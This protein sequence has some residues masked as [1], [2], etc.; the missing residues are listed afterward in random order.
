MLFAAALMVVGGTGAFFSD[1]ETSTGNVFTAG[2]IDLLVNHSAQSYNGV[3]CQTCGVEIVSSE[4]TRVVDSSAGAASEGDLPKNAELIANPNPNW[5]DANDPA[6][7][8]AEWIWVEPEVDVAD[9]T[10]D[11]EYT[12]EDVFSLQGPIALT[13]FELEIAS[14]NGYKI[15]LNGTTIVDR[16]SVEDT[17]TGLNPL[18]SQ[19]QTD[20]QNA[21]IENGQNT[22][23]I[24]V[25]NHEGVENPDQ[26]PAG[27]IYKIE[28]TNEDC[29]AGV[30]DFQA[31]CEL[32]QSIDLT[33]ESFFDFSDIKPQDEGTNRISLTVED[34]EA[35][36]CLGVANPENIENS[37]LDIEQEAG[38]DS[39][40][41]GE[42][43][44][45]LQVAGWYTDAAGNLGNMLFG[46]TAADDLESIAYA[47]SNVGTPIQPGNTE[48]VELAWCLGEMTADENGYT[49]D[50]IVPDINQTQTDAFLADLQFYAV[51]TRNN[52]DFTC[53]GYFGTGST[54]PEEEVI[55]CSEEADVMLVLDSSGSVSGDMGTLRDAAKSFI[56][57]LQ[58]SSG[59]VE[60]GVVD[61]D[62]DGVL[63]Q[64]LTGNATSAKDQIDTL[65]AGGQTYLDEGIAT[66]QQELD[67]NGRTGVP[68]FMLIVSDGDANDEPAAAAEAS[69]S[70]DAGVTIFAVGVGGNID[71]TFLENQIVTQPASD[72]YFA[73][74]DFEALENELD[75]ILKCE[76]PQ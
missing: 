74:S 66:A 17:Y 7:A 3:S 4:N 50:G 5:L 45:F 44:A 76:V 64:G 6:V 39:D 23:Q 75:E 16:L 24:T 67:D 68:Q 35:Y 8:P 62:N 12:F 2:A 31:T 61:F 42:M 30:G 34:N 33:N 21:L 57:A 13:D 52:D 56:D 46:P 40:D 27:L 41:T 37:Y 58:V 70:R 71:P 9:T 47:D 26:N 51:Q 14:D 43:G 10:N 25:R 18:T 20:F 22:L 11:A 29:E 59:G 32:W 65:T 60:V 72:Y 63:V 36:M 38:D 19:Q 15:V 49:C 55:G 28:F 48:Y 69:D 73:A 53:A 54:T 1:S